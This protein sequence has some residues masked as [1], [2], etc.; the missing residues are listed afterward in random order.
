MVDSDALTIIRATSFKKLLG[1]RGNFAIELPVTDDVDLDPPL[2]SYRVTEPTGR[3]YS[4]AVPSDTPVLVSEGDPLDGERVIELSE[5]SPVGIAGSYLPAAVVLPVTSFGAVGDG[6][7]DDTTAIQAA[8]DAAPDD[9]TVLL[10]D[11]YT[12]R[13]TD[14]L[15]VDH[16]LRLTGRGKLNFTSGITNK[17]AVHVTADGCDI[18]GMRVYNVNS[19][20]S[21]TGDANRGISLECDEAIVQNCLVSQWQLGIVAEPTGEF[22]N[23][24]IVNNRV[25]D[26]L[27]AGDGPADAES[28]FGEDRGDGITVWASQAV[29]TGNIV[30]AKSGTDARAGIHFEGLPGLEGVTTYLSDSLVNI[31]QNI[32]YG[33]FR[34]GIVAEDVYS[35][36]IVDNGV[37]DSTWWCIA[38]I[39]AADSTVANNRVVWTREAAD[40]QGEAWSPLRAPMMCLRACVNSSFENNRV[41]CSPTSE[42]FAFMVARAEETDIPRD[43]DVSN[44]GFRIESGADV[45]YGVISDTETSGLR[46]LNNKIKGFN[47]RGFFGFS[48][49]NVEIRGNEFDGLTTPANSFGIH[50]SEDDGGPVK[51]VGNTVRNCVTG[52]ERANGVGAMVVQN[53]IIGC[54]NGIEGFGCGDSLFTQNIITGTSGFTLANVTDGVDGNV[55][56][57]NVIS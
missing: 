29:V 43:I 1:T 18:D 31:S 33:K 14:T 3:V 51:I 34:R 13:C 56:S 57:Q 11:K 27:G 35:V 36:G 46:V 54:T 19:L 41:G 24:R 25:R 38:L 49:N 50:L 23:F 42:A 21:Q 7:T 26:V 28:E 44:N 8:L 6:T 20:G 4:I 30:N 45:S 48:A 15:L 2:F 12:F 16:P 52:I 37:S 32:V 9:S 55:V 17:P 39:N 22:Q 10:P 53:Q 47:V 5:I 40:L